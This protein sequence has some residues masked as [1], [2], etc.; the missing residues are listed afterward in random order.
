MNYNSHSEPG[1]IVI[2]RYTRA[3]AYSVNMLQLE[4]PLNQSHEN[5]TGRGQ[6]LVL[7][8]LMENS[9]PRRANNFTATRVPKRFV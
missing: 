7:C 8:D 3:F 1:I 2:H 5:S 9:C 6:H 4:F